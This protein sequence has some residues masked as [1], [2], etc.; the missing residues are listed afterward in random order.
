MQ[1]F[2]DSGNGYEVIRLKTPAE[3]EPSP[4]VEPSP[5]FNAEG[6]VVAWLNTSSSALPLEA[7]AGIVVDKTSSI[8][9]SE[10]SEGL[11][12]CNIKKPESITA[13][14]TLDAVEM[15]T[16]EG[17]PPFSFTIEFPRDWKYFRLASAGR[18]ILRAANEEAGVC[19]E[20]R[21]L[22]QQSDDLQIA[23][24]KSETM[25]ASGLSRSDLAPFSGEALSGLKADYVETDPDSE[26]AVTA[27]YTM[28]NKNFYILAMRYPQQYAEEVHRLLDQI[29][30]SLK[31]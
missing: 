31:I 9:L 17:H 28:S 24:Q 10:A 23:V 12:I 15:K 20:L 18:Y 5:V 27:Y 22:P 30:S 29:V 13:P 8:S 21:I 6:K 16:T 3:Q 4:K 2:I 7:I 11:R 19:V 1:N 14:K 26:F 25:F